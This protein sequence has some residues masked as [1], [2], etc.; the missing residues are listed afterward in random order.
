[1][2]DYFRVDTRPTAETSRYDYLLRPRGGPNTQFAE[3][4]NVAEF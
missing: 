4:E 1:M 2:F 3:Q